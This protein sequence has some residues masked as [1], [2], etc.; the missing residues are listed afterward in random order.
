MRF[1]PP[2]PYFAPLI[3]LIFGLTA[4]WLGYE[5][6]L[7]NDLARNLAD[8]ADHAASAGT[9]LVKISERHMARGEVAA[10]AD[11]LA[12][13]ADEPWLRMAAV[14]D[15]KGGGAARSGKCC[16]GQAAPRT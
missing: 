10:I 4:M 12:A 13:W 9:R 11:E 15:E 3:V 6:N 2:A 7:A 1:P 16:A 5:L 14:L 8:V